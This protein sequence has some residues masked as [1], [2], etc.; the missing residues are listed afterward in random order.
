MAKSFI[1][2]TETLGNPPDGVIISCA[3]LVFDFDTPHTFKELINNACYIKF[4]IAEQ[5]A[6]GR[7]INPDYVAWWKKQSKA[8]KKELIPTNKDVT[9]VEGLKQIKDYLNANGITSRKDTYAFC[10]GQSFDFPLLEHIHW[11]TNLQHY[12]LCDFW[13]QR[14]S[15]TF[16]GST[17]GDITRDK[18]PL[19]NSVFNE[20]DFIAHNCVHDIAKD[21]LM[22]QY[23]VKYAY[24]EEEL[25]SENTKSL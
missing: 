9:A 6:L 2:D 21:V 3:V 12:W 17:L 18:V 5:R 10:R 11:Q 16:I 19:P 24:G 1:F 23:A 7:K 15:R 20:D 22:M 25:P 13:K 4:D 14:D 8:A